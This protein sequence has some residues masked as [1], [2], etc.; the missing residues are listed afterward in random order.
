MRPIARVRAQ[1]LVIVGFVVSALAGVISYFQYRHAPAATTSMRSTGRDPVAQSV[2]LIAAVVRVV[3]VDA[4]EASDEQQRSESFDGP[5]VAFAPSTCS[6]ASSSCSS[7]R[8]FDTLG[9]FWLTTV[10]WGQLIGAFI[11]ALGLFL[12][13]RTLSARDV[14]STYDPDP[15]ASD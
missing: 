15:A 5:I 1:A 12:L 13:S 4:V 10:L 6:S 2:T 7:S 14:S 8:H 11:A 3:V 9:G